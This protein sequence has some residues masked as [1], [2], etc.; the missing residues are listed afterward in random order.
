M[1]LVQEENLCPACSVEVHVEIIL[2]TLKQTTLPRAT[3]S[4]IPL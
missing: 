2:I 4:P 1:G 3:M